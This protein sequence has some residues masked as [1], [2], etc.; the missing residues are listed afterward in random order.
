[1]KENIFIVGNLIWIKIDSCDTYGSKTPQYM[2]CGRTGGLNL[3]A[4]LT[5]DEILKR[6]PDAK[7][8]E[9]INVSNTITYNDN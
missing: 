3:N 9:G 4:I 6:Y 2:L 1:M 7:A 5:K 8:K